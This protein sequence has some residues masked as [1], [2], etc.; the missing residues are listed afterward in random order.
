[1]VNLPTEKPPVY[2]TKVEFF[3]LIHSMNLV[4]SLGIGASALSAMS[5]FNHRIGSFKFGIVLVQDDFIDK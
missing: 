1:M 2:Y 3:I 5:I 4:H